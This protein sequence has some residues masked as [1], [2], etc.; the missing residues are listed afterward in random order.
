MI[1]QEDIIYFV[2]TD[3]FANGDTAND[4]GVDTSRPKAYHGGDFAGLIE[5]IPYFT[6]LGITAVW[7]TP[8]YVNITDFFGDAGYHG[9]WPID[10]ELV[11][12]HLYGVMP[13]REK[14]SKAYLKDL[15]DT[16]RAGGLKIILD[17]VVNHTGY[18]TPEYSAYPDKK[19][20]HHHFN[21]P[22]QWDDVNRYL[23]GLPDLDHD[24]P[25]VSDY[26]IQNII[27]WITATG[28]DGIRMDTVRH[29]ED[30][31]WYLYKSQIKTKHP[32]VTLIGEI[33]EWDPGFIG[34]F[35]QEHDFDTVFDF[36]L[37]GQMKGSIVWDQPMTKLAR[38]RLHPLE[39]KG[40]LDRNK[41]YTNA[42]RLVTLLDNH[43]LDRRIMT[44]I[45]AKVAYWDKDLAREILKCCLTVQFTTRGIPQLYYGTE[46]GMEGGGDPDNRRDMPWDIYGA[47]N[48][49]KTTHPFE[50]DLFEHTTK[51]IAI[52]KK[53]PAICFGY[54]LT[55]YADHYVYAYMR[56]FRGN[57][58]IV[59]VNNGREAM[60]FPL[61]V[62]IT[63]N[64]NIPPRI[65]SLLGNGVE[66]KSQFDNIQDLTMTAGNIDVQL[67]RK[68]A[69]VWVL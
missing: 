53:N 12:N 32:E 56:E 69:G 8:V 37:C 25:E 30:R 68:T 60:P 3:R 58:V 55:L 40:I 20:T 26:F 49:P 42:N 48:I 35:Q 16:F 9:Y 33:L 21:A 6:K 28:I 65:K 7:I 27:D 24:N 36:P 29:V 1:S 66:L 62:K 13:G 4:A 57:I 43:D 47:D 18:H 46:I 19:F 61:P 51:V 23:Y 63:T 52:R 41:E 22:N 5:K 38:P 54:L 39:E 14:G 44:D 31:F 34:R 15:V 50:R 17:M 59:V 64:S 67:P 45:F 10:F 2:L 11:D